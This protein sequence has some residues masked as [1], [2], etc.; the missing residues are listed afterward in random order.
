MAGAATILPMKK[1]KKSGRR[2]PKKK[3]DRREECKKAREKRWEAKQ[4]EQARA[5]AFA[6]ARQLIVQLQAEFANLRAACQRLHRIHTD[7]HRLRMRAE[8][9]LRILRSRRA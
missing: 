6:K 7:E 2:D 5:A 8:A 4:Q 9:T 3:R 1:K